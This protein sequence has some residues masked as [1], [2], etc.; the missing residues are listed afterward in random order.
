MTLPFYLEWDELRRETDDSC[1]SRN[2]IET[3]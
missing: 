3:L 1:Y 2:K